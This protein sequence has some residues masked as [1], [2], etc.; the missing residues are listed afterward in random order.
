PDAALQRLQRRGLAVAVHEP[1]RV[2]G[3]GLGR[4]RFGLRT[5]L[6]A[7][8]RDVAADRGVGGRRAEDLAQPRAGVREEDVVDEGDGGGGPLDVEEHHAG[9]RDQAPLGRY[10]GPRHTGWKRPSTPLSV[11][12][13][14]QPDA[15]WKS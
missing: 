11:Y 12:W 7:Q 13:G 5:V 4:A 6:G 15:S 2:G 1:G 14:V 3:G 9:W 8:G 10:A